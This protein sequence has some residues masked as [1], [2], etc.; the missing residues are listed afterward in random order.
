MVLYFTAL[1]FLKKGG[2][3]VKYGFVLM[4]KCRPGFVGF[5]DK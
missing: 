1:T 4:H 5:K 2:Y 3:S